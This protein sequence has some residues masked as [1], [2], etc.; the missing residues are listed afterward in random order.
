MPSTRE[1]APAGSR[2]TKSIAQVV[3]ELWELLRDYAK[4][5]TVDPLKGLFH[6]VAYGVGGA[7]LLS[8]GIVLLAIG[9]L[10]AL[11]T[12]TDEHL[13][14]NWSWLPYFATLIVLAILIALSVS[15]IRRESK[16]AR[17]KR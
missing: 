6:Y 13:T 14:G 17:S 12:H 11:Q 9:G 7:L 5:E 4:Q 10:R 15:A 8:L 2:S 1:Q 3:S 16:P